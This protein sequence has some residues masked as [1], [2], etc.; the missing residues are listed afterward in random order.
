MLMNFLPTTVHDEQVLYACDI[1]SAISTIFVH[2]ERVKWEI[3]IIS[4]EYPSE[5]KI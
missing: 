1:S 3:I 4:A 2:Y 5:Q